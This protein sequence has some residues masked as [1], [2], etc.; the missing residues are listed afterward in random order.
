MKRPTVDQLPSVPTVDQL[1]SVPAIHQSIVAELDGFYPYTR[2]L[3]TY[4]VDRGDFRLSM[5]LLNVFV[6]HVD[7][8]VRPGTGTSIHHYKNETSI[9][10]RDTDDLTILRCHISKMLDIL[11]FLSTLRKET[12]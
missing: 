3:D 5:K 11:W 6:V 1:P 9:M 8:G 7:L 4:T 12:T 10:I 2:T